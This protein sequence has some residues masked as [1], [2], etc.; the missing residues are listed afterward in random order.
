MNFKDKNKSNSP[1]LEI[2]GLQKSFSNDGIRVQVLKD[3]SCSIYS[4][5]V[6]GIVGSSGVGKTTFLHI[7]G[8]L[9]RPTDGSV[10]HFGQNAFSWDDRRLSRFRNEKIG[11]VF[12][13][14][15]LLPEFSALENVM[16]PCILSGMSRSEAGARA[17]KILDE[18]G[19]SD[20]VDHRPG[21]MSGGE[22]QRVALARAMVRQPRLLLADEPT[23][24][25]D[26]K[27]GEKVVDLIFSLNRRYGTT[28]VLVT[29]D[30]S[31]ARKMDRCLGLIDGRAVALNR[32][33][34]KEFGVG[35]D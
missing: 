14:H 15:H 3:V 12:Q 8:T 24:N 29:H 1:D 25:L 31:L 32:E 2:K 19:L 11:F 16:M 27:T 10:L 4:G 30:L 20:R 5:E 18:L 23:G 28:V 9:D 17:K 34:L 21:N 26:K 6:V 13:F 35:K 22:Q 33:D 7:L